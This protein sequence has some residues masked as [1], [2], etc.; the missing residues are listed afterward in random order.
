MAAPLW[1]ES[2]FEARLIINN[3]RIHSTYVKLILRHPYHKLAALRFGIT[4]I[5]DPFLVFY[6]DM[7]H[8]KFVVW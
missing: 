3:T 4:E 8:I 2:Q 1:L 5:V 6:S 7:I